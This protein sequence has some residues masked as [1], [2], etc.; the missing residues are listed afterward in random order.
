MRNKTIALSTTLFMLTGCVAIWGGGYKIESSSESNI[1]IRYDHH[2]A[3]MDDVQNVAQ[4][5]CRQVDKTAAVRS[6][7]TSEW[8]LTTVY[9]TCGAATAPEVKGTEKAD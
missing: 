8:G 4:N 3:S 9:F 1:E 2:F 5:H 7:S 6:Q